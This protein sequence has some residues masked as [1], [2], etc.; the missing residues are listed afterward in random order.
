MDEQ[1]YV[2]VDR[3]PPGEEWQEG[4]LPEPPKALGVVTHKLHLDR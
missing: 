2:H 1:G 4:G 3:P